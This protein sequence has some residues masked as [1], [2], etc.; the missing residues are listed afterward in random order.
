MDLLPLKHYITV[1]V[2]SCQ[3]FLPDKYATYGPDSH[4]V[5]RKH[6]MLLTNNCWYILVLG[7][8]NR[9]CTSTNTTTDVCGNVTSTLKLP[10]RITTFKSNAL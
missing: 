6:N 1:V 7:T 2:L 9:I 8:Y 4:Y 5:T 10:I 3:L